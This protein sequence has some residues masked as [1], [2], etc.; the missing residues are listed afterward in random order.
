M[1]KSRKFAEGMTPCFILWNASQDVGT[2]QGLT[3]EAFAKLVQTLGG[4]RIQDGVLL[5]DSSPDTALNGQN[6][7]NKKC[8]VIRSDMMSSDTWKRL[9]VRCN[10]P[11]MM[12]YAGKPKFTCMLLNSAKLTN[13]TQI[14]TAFCWEKQFTKERCSSCCWS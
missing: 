14:I 8:C 1:I 13:S 9:C 2:I 5:H 12:K 7:R 11:D 4:L 6:E 10:A 3:L